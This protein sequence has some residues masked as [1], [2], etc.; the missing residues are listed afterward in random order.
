MPVVIK[1]DGRRET[2]HREKLFAGIHA[3]CQ[4]RNIPTVKIEQILA[5]I[6]RKIQSYGLKEIP[7]RTV[8]QMVMAELHLLDKVAY[9]RF[10]SVYREFRDVEEFVAELKEPMPSVQDDASLSFTFNETKGNS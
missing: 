9:V 6:E 1:K 7:S 3:A 8:G 4:K 10:A 5:R 2:F